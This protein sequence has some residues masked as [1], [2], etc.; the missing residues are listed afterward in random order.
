ME[1]ESIVRLCHVQVLAIAKR[2]HLSLIAAHSAWIQLTSF[3]G[4]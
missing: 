2:G 3:L 4:I 1:A